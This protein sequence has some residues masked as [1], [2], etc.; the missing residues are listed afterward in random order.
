MMELYTRSQTRLRVRL[1]SP[2][3]L[4]RARHGSSPGG[5]APREEAARGGCPATILGSAEGAAGDAHRERGRPPPPPRRP[6]QGDALRTNLSGGHARLP[7]HL[8]EP[9]AVDHGLRAGACVSTSSPAATT[10]PPAA[11]RQC[12]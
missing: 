11:V 9:P 1:P 2:G 6:P 5:T 3:S 4:C 8:G 7:Q 12:G 10:V